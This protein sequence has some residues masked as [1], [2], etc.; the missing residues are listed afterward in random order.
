MTHIQE[1]E[2]SILAVPEMTEIDLLYS[3]TTQDIISASANH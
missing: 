3:V 2:Q 1:K